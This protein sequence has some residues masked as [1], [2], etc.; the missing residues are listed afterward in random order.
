MAPIF[1][2]P[3]VAGLG[4]VIAPCWCSPFFYN[5]L[6]VLLRALIIAIQREYSSQIPPHTWL[7]YWAL[8]AP[9]CI[10]VQTTAWLPRSSPLSLCSMAESLT[11]HQAIYPPKNNNASS[12]ILTGLDWYRNQSIYNSHH[13][14]VICSGSRIGDIPGHTMSWYA[15]IKIGE[16]DPP[17]MN[18]RPTCIG[19][20]TFIIQHKKKYQAIFYRK[21]LPSSLFNGRLIG[22]PVF[23]IFFSR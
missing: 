9:D 8:P 2:K 17:Y 10:T 12:I 14:A 22:T 16:T 4:N 5:Q 23:T 18:K 7:Q 21:V 3:S 20:L 11:L 1:K 19:K 13:Y 15:F 6:R